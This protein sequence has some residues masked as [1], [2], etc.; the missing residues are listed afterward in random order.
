[1]SNP[2]ALLNIAVMSWRSAA[3]PPARLPPRYWRKVDACLH[4]P[5][6][7]ALALRH[8]DRM[9]KHGPRTFSCFIYRVANPTMHGLSMPPR[10][11]FRGKGALLS[12]LADDSFGKTPCWHSRRSITYPPRST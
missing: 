6:R 11:V 8:F 5:D 12:V 4:Q 1:M 9:M 2:I 10:N 3:A 7:V